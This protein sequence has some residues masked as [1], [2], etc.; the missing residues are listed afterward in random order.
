MSQ[1]TFGEFFSNADES[2]SKETK[3]NPTAVQPEKKESWYKGRVLSH[4]SINLYQACPQKWKFKYIDKVPEKPKSF[5]SF[6]KSVHSGLEFLFSKAR[7]EM[8]T[9]DEIIAQY[10]LKWIREGYDTVAQEKWFFQEGERII[11][12][13]Y[14]KHQ[15]DFKTVAHVELRFN[16]NIEGVPLLGFIDRIDDTPS[17]KLAIVD[18]KTGKAF[19]KTR[20]RKDP[21]L[22]L[23]QMAVREVLG[24]EVESVTLYHLNSLTPLKVPA[25]SKELEDQYKV[26]VV[27]S[28]TGIMKN[29][30]E[31]KPD[32]K[33]Q[34][35]WCDYV[36]ICPAFAG[37]KLPMTLA[38]SNGESTIELVD[39]FGKLETRINELLEEKQK[40]SETLRSS[41]DQSGATDAKGEYYIV[42]VVPTASGEGTELRS[43]LQ[44]D[45]EN[46][47]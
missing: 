24:K 34:C 26:T 28:A 21:Q 7:S 13:F 9:L 8:P 43:E 11:R 36:Q 35:Q 42:R 44:K 17:G 1:L 33:G 45:K 25:H 31:P 30:F 20:V 27:E 32:A 41:L 23:Y 14:A 46:P 15:N 39:R 16:V 4:S 10:K 22:T 5:F 37:K 2:V 12:G 18:Y 47:S 29:V 19:D 6:G 3:K 38:Q 40:L